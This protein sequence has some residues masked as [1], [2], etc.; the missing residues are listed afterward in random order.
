MLGLSCLLYKPRALLT[1]PRIRP[2]SLGRGKRAESGVKRAKSE[3]QHDPLL[4]PGTQGCL[5]LFVY[6]V[7]RDSPTARRTMRGSNVTPCKPSARG[8]DLSLGNDQ[9]L[10]SQVNRNQISRM[11]MKENINYEVVRGLVSETHSHRLS[12]SPC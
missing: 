1:T 4:A 12:E 10:K 6:K 5:R 7:G 8:K 9:T 11:R 2:G 3:P